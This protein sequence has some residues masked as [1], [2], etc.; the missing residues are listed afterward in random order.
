[1]AKWMLKATSEH[2]TPGR[3]LVRGNWWRPWLSSSWWC[4]DLRSCGKTLVADVLAVVGGL[5]ESFL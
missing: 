4:G 3:V 2:G 1:M 5:L